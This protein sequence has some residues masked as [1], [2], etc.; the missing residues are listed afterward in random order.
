M[1]MHLII[2]ACAAALFVPAS[3]G[4]QGQCV[5]REPCTQDDYGRRIVERVREGTDAVIRNSNPAG[6]AAEVQATL[7]ECARCAMEAAQDGANRVIDAMSSEPRQSRES[8]D[9]SSQRRDPDD[10]EARLS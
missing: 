2:A 1:K 8:D 6:R 5:E 3:A 7:E 10:P 9:D 4:A